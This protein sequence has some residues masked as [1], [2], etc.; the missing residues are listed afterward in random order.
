ML[1]IYKYNEKVHQKMNKVDLLEKYN[2]LKLMDPI[3][4]Y[5]SLEYSILHDITIDIFKG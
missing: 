5:R 2:E 1:D 3:F 4:E